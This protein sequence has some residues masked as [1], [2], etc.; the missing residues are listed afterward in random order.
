MVI[1]TPSRDKRSRSSSSSIENTSVRFRSFRHAP[2]GHRAAGA[3]YALQ[4]VVQMS[5]THAAPRA[6]SGTGRAVVVLGVLV[7]LLASLSFLRGTLHSLRVY[8]YHVGHA[9]TRFH[10]PTAHQLRS[11]AATDRS[12]PAR[13]ISVAQADVVDVQTVPTVP[14][15]GASRTASEHHRCAHMRVAARWFPAG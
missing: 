9:H 6:W 3:E 5:R 14:P 1:F 8:D 2:A 13:R 12:S 10:F 7:A 4:V 15:P 11:D